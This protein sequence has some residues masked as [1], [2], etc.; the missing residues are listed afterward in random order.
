MKK[1]ILSLFLILCLSIPFKI[2][3]KSYQEL[4]DSNYQYLDYSDTKIRDKINTV[5]GLFDA[6]NELK[7]YSEDN[8]MN[9]IINFASSNNFKNYFVIKVIF[10]DKDND[11]TYIQ[12]FHT[13]RQMNFSLSAK[14]E[15]N[16]FYL[17]SQASSEI[18][19]TGG[20]NYNE[21]LS[22]IKNY[23]D[24]D[25]SMKWSNYY[26]NNYGPLNSNKTNNILDINSSNYYNEFHIPIY[27][28]VSIKLQLR[29]DLENGK[30][31]PLFYRLSENG[32]YYEL[33]VNENFI[34]LFQ[35]EESLKPKFTYEILEKDDNKKDVKVNFFNM[36]DK[37]IVKY[38]NLVTGEQDIVLNL[39][40]DQ[41]SPVHYFI[42]INLDTI[43]TITIYEK[44]TNEEIFSDTIDVSI[45]DLNLK[46]D[47]YIKIISLNHKVNNTVTYKY[48][49]TKKDMKCFFQFAGKDEIEQDCTKDSYTLQSTYNTY[50]RFSI[51]DKNG[52]V[53]NTRV[54]NFQY[55]SNYPQISIQTYFDNVS[56]AQKVYIN[57]KNYK[58]NDVFSYSL[59]NKNYENFNTPK[60]ELS[61]YMNTDLYVKVTRDN[62]TVSEAYLYVI[63]KS[64]DNSNSSGTGDLNSY[65]NLIDYFINLSDF[66]KTFG[67]IIS[68]I[69][70]FL[71]KTPILIYLMLLIS[72]TCIIL[73]I[74]GLN[75]D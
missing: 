37:Y 14:A 66:N 35:T 34:P 18:N 41:S 26:F 7:K 59:D 3:A 40:P 1:V 61:F 17:Y 73:I 62:E 55:L 72:G 23:I 58:E 52:K 64:S 45:Y 75:R 67:E 49:N 36:S 24:N 16:Q 13:T 70:N 46:K 27:S 20:T 71:R 68:Y 50:I 2:Y 11:N 39:P 10:L 12:S 48:E 8:N 29:D 15:Y 19:D 4:P 47:P 60:L 9:Y 32:D 22:K 56:N 6:I 25:K 54:I 53:I 65:N 51:K 69:F 30:N 28:N 57:V 38:S 33:P 31:V 42:N 44:S 5:P 21:N 63:Y 43:I 74:K